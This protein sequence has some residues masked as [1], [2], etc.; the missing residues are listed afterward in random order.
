MKLC[1]ERSS[2]VSEGRK[3]TSSQ[4]VST[5]RKT[6]ASPSKGESAIFL[7]SI[8]SNGLYSSETLSSHRTLPTTILYS[9]KGLLLYDRVSRAQPASLFLCASHS[10]SDNVCSANPTHLPPFIPLPKLVEEPEYYLWR[11]EI[12]ILQKHSHEIA[13]RIFGHTTNASAKHCKAS[14]KSREEHR[15]DQKQEEYEKNYPESADAI[16]EKWGD[17]KVGKHNG[18]VNAEEGLD[19]DRAV[20]CASLVELGAGSLRK[21]SPPQE[22]YCMLLQAHCSC[23]L[24]PFC[25]CPCTDGSPDSCPSRSA[26]G[27][28]HIRRSSSQCPVLCAG[29]GQGRARANAGRAAQTGSHCQGQTG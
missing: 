26:R 17:Q 25:S 18:G 9:E 28:K 2:Q 3:R 11:A 21:V 4:A 6:A 24:S 1:A 29:P 20:G 8:Y 27:R 19:G 23:R 12:N 5:A 7:L 13:P 16:K 10:P 22:G 14:L 15:E